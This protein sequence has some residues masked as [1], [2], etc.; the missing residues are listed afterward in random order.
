MLFRS[1][2]TFHH[3]I[4]EKED[5]I[6]SIIVKQKYADNQPH[7][8]ELELV[9]KYE[10]EDGIIITLRDIV[11]SDMFLYKVTSSQTDIGTRAIFDFTKNFCTIQS[12]PSYHN[13]YRIENWIFFNNK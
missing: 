6:F 1:I 5:K 2:N 11:T 7:K 13:E 8:L 10:I 3:K 12:K 9:E 4:I